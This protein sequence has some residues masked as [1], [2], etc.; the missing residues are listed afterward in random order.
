MW[1]TQILSLTGNLAKFKITH[2]I[3]AHSM[4]PASLTRCISLFISSDS[5]SIFC[6]VRARTLIQKYCGTQL[7]RRAW[8]NFFPTRLYNLRSKLTCPLSTWC[9]EQALHALFLASPHH[10]FERDYYP[11]KV[12]I[13]SEQRQFILGLEVVIFPKIE[14]VDPTTYKVKPTI[15]IKYLS[16]SICIHTRTYT[17]YARICIPT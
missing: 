15:Y 1:P 16:I 10:I 8:Q 17:L 9:C 7:P 12:S 13:S 14:L 3:S 4:F 11:S 2:S 6:H 5:H